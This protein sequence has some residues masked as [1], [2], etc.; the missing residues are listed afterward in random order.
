MG[1]LGE[2]APEQFQ[3]REKFEEGLTA[4]RLRDWDEARACFESCLC[5]DAQDGPSR[6][7]IDRVNQLR[8]SRSPPDLDSVLVED[9]PRSFGLRILDQL[10]SVGDIFPLAP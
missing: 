3:M 2:L 6:L 5:G 4:Y 7:F 1:R 10:L 9:H 8:R